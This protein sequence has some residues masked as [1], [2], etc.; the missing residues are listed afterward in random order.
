MLATNLASFYAKSGYNTALV[1]FDP[2]GT[3][4]HWLKSRDEEKMDIHGI[5]AS[6]IPTNVTRSYYMRM[7]P[8]IERVVIDT[9]AAVKGA[10]LQEFIQQADCIILPVLPSK[11]DIHAVAHFIE[12]L[13]L[14]IK[15]KT[16]NA[17]V[18]VVA[19]RVRRNTK[20]L[21]TLENFLTHIKF[22]FV[23][24]FRETQNY[25]HAAQEGMGV[26]EM[27]PPSRFAK[28]IAQWQTLLD[29]LE[30]DSTIE[31]KNNLSSAF[32]TSNN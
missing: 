9:P 17:K 32:S 22:P 28:D 16:Y 1:D 27:R 3:S 21:K 13:L 31:T 12:M 15:I 24:S 5:D 19:N 11:G 23:T 18:C 7:P 20:I 6:Q 26:C 30:S 14:D 29:W 8:T 2:Q 10:E 25:I 4:V